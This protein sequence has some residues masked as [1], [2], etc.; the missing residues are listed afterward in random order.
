MWGPWNGPMWGVWWIF[1][2]IGMIVC[3]GF[4]AMMVWTFVRGGGVR[5][6]TDHGSRGTDQH[7][8][9]QRDVRELREEIQKLRTAR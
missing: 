3:F 2:L 7:A 9:L 6:M 5:C 8:D 4:M 1:P